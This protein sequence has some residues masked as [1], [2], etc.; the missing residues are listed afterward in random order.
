MMITPLFTLLGNTVWTMIR[1]KRVPP[2]P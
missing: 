2:A 1:R